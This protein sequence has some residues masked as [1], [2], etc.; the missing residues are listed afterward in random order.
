MMVIS[1]RHAPRQ[2]AY[3]QETLAALED[4]AASNAMGQ[5]RGLNG[6]G[7]SSKPTYHKGKGKIA[8]P[9]PPTAGPLGMASSWVSHV[10]YI[11]LDEQDAIL[12]EQRTAVNLRF[13]QHDIGTCPDTG[14][15]CTRSCLNNAEIYLLAHTG[16][17]VF[18]IVCRGVHSG[19]Q[20]RILCTAPYGHGII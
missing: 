7:K 5:E 13:V 6:K 8:D 10:A 19:P 17:L 16:V 15:F 2:R 9:N 1:R 14:Y 12:E 4:N 18:S 3:K 11:Q 20:F